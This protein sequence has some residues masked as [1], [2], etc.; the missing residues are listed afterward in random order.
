MRSCIVI[1]ILI[2]VRVSKVKEAR[3]MKFSEEAASQKSR[4]SRLSQI[5]I[6]F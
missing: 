2:I 3:M 6:E 5:G 1:H 4:S